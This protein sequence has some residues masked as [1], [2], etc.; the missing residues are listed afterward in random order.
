MIRISK[1]AQIIVVAAFDVQLAKTAV[2]KNNFDIA[3]TTV[4]ETI[5]KQ[6][7]EKT[8]WQQ[9]APLALGQRVRVEKLARDRRIKTARGLLL[10]LSARQLAACKVI[11][12]PACR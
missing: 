7:A 3:K 5:S 11:V 2:T 4:E 12:S 1:L 8:A 10:L 6:A 9:V